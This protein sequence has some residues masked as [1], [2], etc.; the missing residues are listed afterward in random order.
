[1]TII[2]FEV[3]YEGRKYDVSYDSSC[4]IRDF[5]L[6]ITFKFMHI[7]TVDQKKCLVKLDDI[8]L[9]VESK[10]DK[11]LGEFIEEYDLICLIHTNDISAGGP[12]YNK[13]INIKFIKYP[14]IISTK[15]KIMRLL[16]F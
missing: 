15:M 12:W 2:N 3:Q 1:M 4:K 10:L 14:I 9:N 8:L 6:D 16:G 5:I 7:K 13:I 11:K